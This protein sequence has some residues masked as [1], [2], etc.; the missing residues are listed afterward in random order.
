MNARA[1]AK[2]SAQLVGDDASH[3]AVGGEVDMGDDNGVLDGVSGRDLPENEGAQIGGLAT[4]FE[5][6]IEFAPTQ[7]LGLH[8]EGVARRREE[9]PRGF[10]WVRVGEGHG[11]PQ[12]TPVQ[13]GDQLATTCPKS[14]ENG[15]K[16]VGRGSCT[17]PRIFR[18]SDRH[19]VS[20]PFRQGLVGWQAGVTFAKAELCIC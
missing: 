2:H 4:K 7:V 8:Q 17:S 13:G 11:N 19:P 5:M 6:R 12:R 9:Y 20:T 14:S 10:G 3:V 15:G 16:H 18:S 1:C